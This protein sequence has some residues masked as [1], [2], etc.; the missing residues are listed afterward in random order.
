MEHHTI[1]HESVLLCKDFSALD[2]LLFATIQQA[3]RKYKTFCPSLTTLG[4][5]VGI[6]RRQTSTSLNK[7]IRKG[8]VSAE[9][10]PGQSSILRITKEPELPNNKRVDGFLPIPS[11]IM[12]QDNR[13]DFPMR[14]RERRYGYTAA[15]KITLA[16]L[17]R[18]KEITESENK[19]YKFYVRDIMKMTGLHYLTVIRCINKLSKWGEIKDQEE[20]PENAEA[21]SEE[22]HLNPA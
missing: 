21:L 6:G 13:V 20:L 9:R 15:V 11:H 17:K 5:W 12:Q 19:S 14:R 1:V 3:C 18:C 4:K 7:L 8:Y 22:L 16:A 2:K 10:S